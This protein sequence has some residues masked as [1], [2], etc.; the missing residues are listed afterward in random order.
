MFVQIRLES[1]GLSTLFAGVR[2]GVGVRLD[3]GSKVGLVR[4]GF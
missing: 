3:V 2:L 4:K 1:K